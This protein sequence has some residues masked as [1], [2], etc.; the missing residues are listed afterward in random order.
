[1][2][3]KVKVP[4]SLKDIKLSQYQKFIRTTK[5]SE[6]ENFIARQM[7]GIF[8]NLPDSVI[9]SMKPKDFD[10]IV[11]DIVNVLSS[12]SELVTTF[13]LDGVEY[14]F[15]PD[16]NDITL[17]EKIDIDTNYK[18]IS[19]LDKAMSVMYRVIS[20]KKKDTYLIEDYTGE[21]KPLDVTLDVV[22]GANVFFST[23]MKDLLNYIQNSIT[24]QVENNPK[25][26]QTLEQNGD[27]TIAFTNSLEVIFSKL[28]Q[29]ASLNYTRR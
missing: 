14:G 5:D 12:K 18:D 15:I 27:G 22:F 24:H 3:L 19:T 23:L 11:S 9:N 8:C 26:S 13:K 29:L 21:E 6:D 1:M 2:K 4:T 20:Y 25:V 28:K 17:G 7:V 10:N 16:F